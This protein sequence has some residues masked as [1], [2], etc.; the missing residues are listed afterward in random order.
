LTVPD[1]FDDRIHNFGTFS[2]L[3]DI[4]L[5]ENNAT[6]NREINMIP[7]NSKLFLNTTIGDINIKWLV[8]TGA[9]VSVLDAKIFKEILKSVHGHQIIKSRKDVITTIKGATGHAFRTLGEFKIPILV[10]GTNFVLPVIVVENLT[11]GAILGLNFLE[12]YNATISTG[13]QEITLCRNNDMVTVA[14]SAKAAVIPPFSSKAIR[15]VSGTN[16]NIVEAIVHGPNLLEGIYKIEEGG[17]ATILYLNDTALPICVN[18]GDKIGTLLTEGA[19]TTAHDVLVARAALSRTLPSNITLAKRVY[20]LEKVKLKLPEEWRSRFLALI[21]EFHDVI[22]ND[23]TD[24]GRTDVIS[25]EV[26]LKNPQPVH[27]KQFRIPWDHQ[28]CVNDYVDKLLE[29]RCIQPSLS[30]F[31]APVFCVPKPHGGGLRVVQDFRQLNV[32]SFEDKY[33]I[34]EVQDCIDQIGLRK[35]RIFTTLD[36]TSGFWQQNLETNSRPY[37]AFTV[38]G[39]G[40][41]E[42]CTTPMGLHGAPASFARLMDHVMR[43]IPGVI[44]YIDD[45]LAHSPTLEQHLSDLRACLSRLRKYNLKLNLGK[46][47]FGTDN[48]AYLG[49]TLT[50]DGV[51]P[52]IEKLLAVKNFPTPSTETNIREFTGLAN[53]FRHM[54]PRYALIAGKLTNLLTKDSGWKGG[55]LPTEALEAFIQLKQA[56]CSAPVLAYPRGDRPFSLATDAATGDAKRPGGLGAVLT[57]VGNDGFEHVVSYA[58]RSLRPN[59]KNYSAFLLEMAAASWAI[60]NYSVYLRGRKFTLYRVRHNSP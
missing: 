30:A 24:L 44:T 38:P 53:Y 28:S 37:T 47:E 34:R 52:G 31:N 59:E 13:R 35:S 57:Q 20:I 50:S 11:A 19:L 29:K 51:K 55:P 54:I 42:W 23:S 39:R 33:I 43:D 58:S 7:G 56:L 40:R 3:F 45:V 48:V 49:F 18:R 1:A 2:A 12:H 8:D 21:L 17:H 10:K 25:H 27:Q 14:L 26:R 36:L 46:C 41:F 16:E 5:N 15:I 4:I 22:S 6:L 9:S 32:A 60:D